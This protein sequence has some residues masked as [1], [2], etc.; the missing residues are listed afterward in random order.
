[1]AQGSGIRLHLQAGVFTGV[2]RSFVLWILVQCRVDDAV[3]DAFRAVSSAIDFDD[4]ITFRVES[5]TFFVHLLASFRNLSRYDDDDDD[6][7]DEEE[8]ISLFLL[9]LSTGERKLRV[10][11]K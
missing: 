5:V 2:Q 9:F 6:D 4:S 11:E 7:N 8:T 3:L 1:M 10:I